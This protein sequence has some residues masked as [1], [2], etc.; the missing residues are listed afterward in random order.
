MSRSILCSILLIAVLAAAACEASPAAS[1]AASPTLAQA[2]SPTELKYALASHFG[3]VFF[4]DPDYYPIGRPGGE[5]QQA[6]EQ[7][8]AIQ[9]QTEEFQSIVEHE[10]LAD[11]VNFTD[12][13][14]LLV[15][16]E[17]KKLNAITLAPSG[18]AY[19]YQ[20]RVEQQDLQ[21]L[22]IEGTISPQGTIAVMKQEPAFTTCPI[23]LTGD[24][25]IQTPE[26]E[27]AVRELQERMLVWTMD[28]SGNRVT[29]PVVKIVRRPVPAEHT[30]VRI[31]LDD[32]RSLVASGAHPLS[33]G[34]VLGGLHVGDRVDGAQVAGITTVDWNEPATYDLL[35]SGDTGRYWAN[36]IIVGSTLRR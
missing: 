32:G 16:R 5:E 13:Q 12:D 4:C 9:A 23:C 6:L 29:A 21:G 31:D 11:V 7:F 3:E 20:L 18:A 10:N 17:H 33:D 24:T 26:G 28:A 19:T 30:M 15:Y 34:R 22:A 14:K 35:P 1:P 2:M 8:P 27:V 25:R 36:G